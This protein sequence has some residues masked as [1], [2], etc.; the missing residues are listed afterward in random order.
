MDTSELRVSIIQS[1]LVWENKS[2]NF[3]H[4]DE[5]IE[6]IELN[7]DLIILPEMFTT[8][9]SM[10]AEVLFDKPEG[11]TLD[12]MRQHAI[13]KQTAITGSAIV[14]VKDSFFNRLYFV[15]PDGSYNTYDKKHLFTLAKEH[16]HYSAG[17][18]KL[19]IEYKGWKICP[20]ICYDL[21]FPVWARNTENYDL[22]IY[23][24]NWPEKRIAAWDALLKARA[25]ENMCYCIGVNRIGQDGNDYPYV[26]HSAIYDTLGQKISTDLFEEAFVETKI[27]SKVHIDNTREKLGFLRDRDSFELL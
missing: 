3:S 5:L 19:I 4:F 6:A 23:V 20:L 21:R 16:E 25:I 24:A 9:F 13:K 7:T 27:L 17:S 2:L 18:R 11:G 12:W 15:K 14:K 8:G 10:N 26:G 22:L 1:D